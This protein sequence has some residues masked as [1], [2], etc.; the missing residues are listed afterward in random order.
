M[1]CVSNRRH[2]RWVATVGSNGWSPVKCTKGPILHGK[3][4]KRQWNDY[5]R[6]KKEN[7]EKKRK[8]RKI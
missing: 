7:M 6:L 1:V 2:C 3:W 4:S 8:E 5:V